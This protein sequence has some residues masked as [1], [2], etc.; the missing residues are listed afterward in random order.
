[1]RRVV[2]ITAFVV[3]ALGGMHIVSA[4]LPAAG[5]AP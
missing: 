4:I 5:M 2:E 1:M 3:V